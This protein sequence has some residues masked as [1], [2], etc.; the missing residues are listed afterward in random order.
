MRHILPLA[1][2]ALLVACGDKKSSDDSDS[3]H[4]MLPAP[5]QRLA[6]AVT[7]PSSPAKSEQAR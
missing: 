3:T 4:L 6:L 7:Q 5:P 1:L 2:I